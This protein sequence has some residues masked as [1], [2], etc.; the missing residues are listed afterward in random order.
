M[1]KLK[2]E[3]LGRLSVEEFKSAEKIPLIIVLDNVRSL[4]NVGSIF[5]TA[6]AFRLQA[7]YLCGCTGVPP[8]KEIHKTALGSTETVSWKYFKTTAEALTDLK[9]SEFKI[10][11]I[12]Q[13]ENSVS[14]SSVQFPATEKL[15]F[16]FGNEVYGVEQE[17]VSASNLCIEI[18]QLG[19]KHSLN[20]S[21]SVGIV[22][23]EI[24]RKFFK[25]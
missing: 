9:T 14:L 25:N 12:E 3:E 4:N 11:A 5:R 17:I 23:W 8:N 10:C 16:I 15:A 2:N 20:I 19:S 18:P 24:A 13:A 1:R 21:V 6:D 22:I 7:V